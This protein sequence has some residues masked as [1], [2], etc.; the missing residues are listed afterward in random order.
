MKIEIQTSR[1]TSELD[2]LAAFSATE[3]PAVTRVVFSGEDLGARE[4]L[5]GLYAD[6]G[7]AVREDAV[8]NTFARWIGSEPEAGAVG[9]GSHI[10]AI[11]HS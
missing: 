3:L 4:W 5:E 11:P 9:T 6:A 7:L 10:D 8:G 1:L 2:R